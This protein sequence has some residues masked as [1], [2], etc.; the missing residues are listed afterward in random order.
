MFAPVCD[1]LNTLHKLSMNMTDAIQPSDSERTAS[2]EH[3][4]IDS[5]TMALSPA[6]CH[7]NAV[8]AQQATCVTLVNLAA[9]C[10]CQHLVSSLQLATNYPTQELA[11]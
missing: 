6:A 8:D 3:P 9:C 1:A 11:G 10:V 4:I 5:V 7:D 2:A